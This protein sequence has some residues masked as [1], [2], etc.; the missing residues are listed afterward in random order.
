MADG[1]LGNGWGM[2]DVGLFSLADGRI[3][4]GQGGGAYPTQNFSAASKLTA[5][6]RSFSERSTSD[7]SLMG[8]S[9]PMEASS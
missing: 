6:A 1:L 7:G 4:V 2:D 5:C 3:V 9:M 8:H